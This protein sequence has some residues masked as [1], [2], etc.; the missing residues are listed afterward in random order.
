MILALGVFVLVVIALC[1]AL[2][3]CGAARLGDRMLDW[4]ADEPEDELERMWRRS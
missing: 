3:L 2:A 1:F 4:P